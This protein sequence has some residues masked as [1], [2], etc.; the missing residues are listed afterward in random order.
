MTFEEYM[1]S[2]V[3]DN[4]GY[5]FEAIGSLG[6]YLLYQTKPVESQ[7]GQYTTKDIVKVYSFPE[8]QKYYNDYKLYQR[9]RKLKRIFNLSF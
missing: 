2:V 3:I 7:I 4:N 6:I 8:S 1:N 5:L 9:K